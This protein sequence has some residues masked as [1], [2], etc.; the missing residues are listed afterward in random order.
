MQAPT[1]ATT[2]N[3]VYAR[4]PGLVLGFYARK[5]RQNAQVG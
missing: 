1:R 5:G 2:H 4:T 3:P